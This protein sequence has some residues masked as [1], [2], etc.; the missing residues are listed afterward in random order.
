MYKPLVL[1]VTLVFLPSFSPLFARPALL[2][3]ASVL[4]EFHDS[5]SV[6]KDYTYDYHS[7]VCR[8]LLDDSD[9]AISQGTI[10]Y[11]VDLASTTL[12]S[13]VA[14]VEHEGKKTPVNPSNIMRGMA[15][16]SLSAFSDIEEHTITFPEVRKG[17]RLC[18]EVRE[19]RTPFIPGYFEWYGVSPFPFVAKGSSLQVDSEIPLEQLIHNDNNFWSITRKK[20][21]EGLHLEAKVKSDY[22]EGSRFEDLSSYSGRGALLLLRS[23]RDYNSAPFKAL[24]AEVESRLNGEV[25]KVLSDLVTKIKERA[26]EQRKQLEIAMAEISNLVRYMGDFRTNEGKF[27]PRK[28]VDT[29]ASDYGDCKDFSLL[30]VKVARLLGIKA[31]YAVVNRGNPARRGDVGLEQSLYLGSNHAIVYIHEE[32]GYFIDPTN[33]AS[34]AEALGDISDRDALV[35]AESAS[36]KRV[37][38]LVEA[39]SLFREH[40]RIEMV[41]D[42][43]FVHCK[44]EFSGIVAAQLLPSL[45]RNPRE[46]NERQILSWHAGNFLDYRFTKLPQF[47]QREVEP[48]E[49]EFEWHQPSS[50]IDTPGGKVIK[51][52]PPFAGLFELKQEKRVSGVDFGFHR[53]ESTLLYQDFHPTHEVA[54]LNTVLDS[55]WL[56]IKREV[57]DSPQGLEISFRFSNKVETLSAEE[58]NSP[59]FVKLQEQYR[60]LMQAKGVVVKKK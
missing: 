2:S 19:T 47:W 58:F 32:G 21:T 36:I 23:H 25:P 38:S 39:A 16:T 6:K 55:K 7:Q 14:W 18:Y 28:I 1:L 8:I 11:P 54:S 31:Y 48:Y 27:L 17:A 30:T 42:I 34:I 49:M 15:T 46:V 57:K 44:H 41:N 53:T 52:Y 50:A 40:C 37:R 13:L 33:T 59:E 5:L 29:L 26:S 60:R 56:L 35:F 9:E 20:G 12:K 4:L 22:A 43:S 24:G 3:E 45:F 51:L 10:K